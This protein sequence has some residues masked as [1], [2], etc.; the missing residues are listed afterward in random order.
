[1]EH[2]SNISDG[3]NEALPRVPPVLSYATPGSP[4]LKTIRQLASFEANLA[5]AKL[6]SAGVTCFLIDDNIATAYPLVFA[7]VKLQ[8]PED[9]VEQAEAVLAAPAAIPADPE[10][11]EA[12]ADQ[13]AADE[14]AA[15]QAAADEAK[16]DDVDETF[17]CPNCHRNDVELMPLSATMRNVR[18]GCL[19]V[20][21]LPVIVS[22]AGWMFSSGGSRG[23]SAA[24]VLSP[25][26]MLAWVVVLAILC[27]IVLTAKRRKHCRTCHH[28]WVG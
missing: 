10:D 22:V 25:E 15:D 19:M 4:K 16:G 27:F 3:T 2:D 17:R 24:D 6:Q 20:L 12:A 8:V 11:D 14:A 28:E 26:A 21:L 7:S 1:M 23:G 5:A 9:E 13:A 18:F